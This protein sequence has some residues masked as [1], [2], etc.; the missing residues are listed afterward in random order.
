MDSVLGS[1]QEIVSSKE[2]H[3]KF[4]VDTA[5]H[6]EG[7]A[8]EDTAF[9]LSADKFQVQYEPPFIVI[10]EK[11]QYVTHPALSI[12]INPTSLMFSSF[13][14]RFSTKSFEGQKLK[15]RQ[16]MHEHHSCISHPPPRKMCLKRPSLLQFFCCSVKKG[17]IILRAREFV[18]FNYYLIN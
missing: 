11:G 10:R 4:T 8:S 13:F 18:E 2:V 17:F 16:S 14:F 7:G 12:L 9:S 6:L 3:M 5:P 1:S 15:W